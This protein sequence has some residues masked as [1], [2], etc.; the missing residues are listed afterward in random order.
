MCKGGSGEGVVTQGTET[1]NRM[2][3]DDVTFLGLRVEA[4]NL[5][6]GDGAFW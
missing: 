1:M 5:P 2:D 6:S 3:L 4:S